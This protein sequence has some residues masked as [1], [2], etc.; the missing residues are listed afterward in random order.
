MEMNTV[1]LIRGQTN[2]GSIKGAAQKGRER[3]SSQKSQKD[4][5]K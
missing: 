1:N 2:S 4:V 3:T 5:E